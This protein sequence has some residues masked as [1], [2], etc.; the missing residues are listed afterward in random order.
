MIISI[1]NAFEATIIFNIILGIILLLSLR[2]KNDKGIF[3]IS[4][5][6]ELKGI[7]ILLVVFSHVGYFLV[8]DNR[9]L[10]PLSDLAGVGVDLFLFLSGLGLT[11]SAFKNKLPILN[12]YHKHFLKLFTP[13]WLTLIGL[14]TLDFFVLKITYSWQFIAKSFLGI[15]TTADIYKDIDSPLWYFTLILFY[16]LVFPI[17]FS[18]K[19]PWLSAIIIY[20]VSYIILYLNIPAIYNVSFFHEKHIIAFPLGMIISWIFYQLADKNKININKYASIIGRYTLIAMLIAFIFYSHSYFRQLTNPDQIQFASIAT[21]LAIIII[22]M[23]KKFEFKLLSLIGVYSYEIYL[24]HWPIMYRYDFIYQYLPAWLATLIYIP[25]LIT[26][27]WLF[28][29]LVDLILN[30]KKPSKNEMKD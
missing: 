3:P 29:K 10:F 18:K 28:K 17:F 15:F 20:A 19:R 13:L 9:F 30:R 22:F 24:L 26:I 14:L 16:Y 12:F 21:V 6:Q 27:A 1:N 25:V 4:L 2:K 8:T 23:A 7:A 5:S 11:A